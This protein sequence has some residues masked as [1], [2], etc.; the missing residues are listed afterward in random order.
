MG[1]EQVIG[2][3]QQLNVSVEL[4]AAIAAELQFRL[5]VEGDPTVRERVQAVAA[6]GLGDLDALSEDELRTALG[7]IKAFFLHAAE[8]VEQPG[9][10]AGWI[11]DNPV[12]LQSQGRAS[13]MVAGLIERIADRLDGLGPALATPEAAFLDIGTGVGWLAVA[14]AR[15]HPALRVVG[16]DIYEPSLELARKNVADSGL[17]DRID[18]RHQ[19]ACT[20]TEESAYDLAW[21]PGPFLPAPI[22][23]AI[24]ARATTATKPGGWV[25]FGLYATAD[26]PAA[27]ALMDLRIVR[28]GGHPWALDEATGLLEDAGLTDVAVIERTWPGPIQF[29]VGRR[30]GD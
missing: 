2:I 27:A 3:T 26:Q 13:M 10:P 7:A 14:M 21:V 30:A 11:T 29:V 25:V 16:C 18:L 17:G 8:L 1:I 6:A 9:R 4:L 5:R 15:T 23:P 12:I 20:L 19:D 22:V 28:S 24:L